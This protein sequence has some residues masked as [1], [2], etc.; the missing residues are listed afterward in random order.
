[1]Q[2]CNDALSARPLGAQRVK[3]QDGRVGLH[4]KAVDRGTQYE[5]NRNWLSSVRSTDPQTGLPSTYFRLID[6]TV[7]GLSCPP[8]RSVF[9]KV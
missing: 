2:K 8:A 1:M 5:L 7:S 9:Q 4:A 6:G 3:S